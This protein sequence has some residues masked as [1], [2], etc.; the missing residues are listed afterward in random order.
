M[1][2]NELSSVSPSGTEA[3]WGWGWWAFQLLLLPSVL[4]ALNGFLAQPISAAELNFV[5]YFV[6]FLAV[7]LIF[8]DFLA[9]SARAVL[10]HPAYFCQ[11]VIL[12][13]AAYAAASFCMNRLLALL[14]PSFQNANDAQ[15]ASLFAGG[16]FLMTLG[17]V[18]LAPVAEECFYRALI[19]RSLYRKAPW[20]GYTV[21]VL[22][23]AAVHV[24]GY[25]GSY[26]PLVLAL[27]FLQYLPAGLC[28][29]WSYAKSGTLFAPI[30]IHC[31]VNFYGIHS[32]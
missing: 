27:S 31:I 7:L 29:A 5:F 17:V 18:L 14:E 32:L 4:N 16:R 13:L 21:S 1:K 30:V 22:V 12:G 25:I 3:V 23:F 19:F 9:R 20:L 28:L 10:A 11:A 24:V 15:L 2:K 6:N 8:H 26:S